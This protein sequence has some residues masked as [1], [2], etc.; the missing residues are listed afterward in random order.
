MWMSLL[1]F[2]IDEVLLYLHIYVNLIIKLL[3]SSIWV[4]YIWN[5]LIILDM[6]FGTLKTCVANCKVIVLPSSNLW[7]IYNQLWISISIHLWVTMS[8]CHYFAQLHIIN[9]I[10]IVFYV[11]LGW[12]YCGMNQ[13]HMNKRPHCPSSFNH[14][15][16]FMTPLWWSKKKLTWL[17]QGFKTLKWNESK[18]PWLQTI[19]QSFHL[20]P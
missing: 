9:H 14:F 17:L 20:L 2:P 12:V 7:K 11:L 3:I 15:W 10:D 8:S 6:C 19:A 5:M 16:T 13:W 1:Y 18:Q 4:D